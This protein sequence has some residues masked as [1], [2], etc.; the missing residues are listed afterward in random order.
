MADWERVPLPIERPTSKYLEAY[1]LEAC[2]VDYTAGLLARYGERDATPNLGGE[3]G[4]YAVLELPSIE[5]VDGNEL[6]IGQLPIVLGAPVTE[7]RSYSI[8]SP[9]VGRHPALNVAVFENRLLTGETAVV[10]SEDEPLDYDELFE[11]TDVLKVIWANFSETMPERT[12]WH[13]LG[14]Y[15]QKLGVTPVKYGYCLR[16]QRTADTTW[17]FRPDELGAAE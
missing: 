15:P 10:D 11:L 2:I 1:V 14:I 17:N 12:H 8:I 3:L 16:H 6:Y 7:S 13:N 4:R 5:L 9:A